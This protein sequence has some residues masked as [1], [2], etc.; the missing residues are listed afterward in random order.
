MRAAVLASYAD[1][2]AGIDSSSTWFMMT[3]LGDPADP[4]GPDEP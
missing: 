3:R 1:Y 4:A 2:Q